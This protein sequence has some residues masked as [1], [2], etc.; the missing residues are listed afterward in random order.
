MK[1]L[2]GLLCI[3]MCFICIMCGCGKKEK[4]NNKIESDNKNAEKAAEVEERKLSADS[5]VISVGDEKIRYD[6]FLVYMYTLKNRYENSIGEGIWSYKLAEG[7]TFE[8]LAREQSI[9]LITELKIISRKAKEYGIELADDEKESIK[10]YAE[11]IYAGISEEDRAAYMLTT[12]NIAKVYMENDIADKVYTAC[13]GGVDTNIN[14][15]DARQITVQ[16]ILVSDAQKAS[17]LRTKAEKKRDF[18]AFARANT[19]ADGIDLTFGKGDMGAEFENA[20]LA[21][22]TGELSQVIQA[23]EGYYII[24]CVS[25]YEQELTAKKKEEIIAAKQ[26]EIFETQYKEWSGE[27]DIQISKLILQ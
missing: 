23:P 16:Y 17:K 15:E 13:I 11:T 7:R 20:A 12:E 27:C 18:S 25:D 24:Y 1:R 2:Y 21:L 9:S 4:I 6:E 3:C 8:S 14:D 5:A 10:K 19:E 22:K 26:K